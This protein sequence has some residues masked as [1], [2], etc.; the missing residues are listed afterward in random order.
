MILISTT[1]LAYDNP[2]RDRN[3]ER[4]KVFQ[5]SDLIIS[6]IFL[7]EAVLKVIAMGFSSY[8]S[9]FGN[10][11]D[12]LIMIFSLLEQIVESQ[13]LRILKVLRP[14]RI[15]NRYQAIQKLITV[16]FISLPN[17]LAI[18]FISSIFYF[19]FSIVFVNLLKGQLYNCR[20][21][22]IGWYLFDDDLYWSET[23]GLDIQTKYECMNYG[24]MWLRADNNF[25]NIGYAMI[26][27]ISISIS[28]WAKQLYL[29]QQT[30]G[31]GLSREYTKKNVT[32]QYFYILF[33]LVCCF[34]ILNLFVSMV[35]A[36]YFQAK[37]R[38]GKLHLLTESQKKYY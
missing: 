2:L 21:L 31:I 4:F 9:N 28:G 12:F 35:I 11:L 22:N 14:L 6:L 18:L 26:N 1:L 24:G 29:S 30:R 13:F 20:L 7:V 32:I 33:M 5:Q 19:V 23:L 37:E 8:I 34:F 15:I 36:V 25:D 10:S 3:D 17:I 27:L 38:F 16:L